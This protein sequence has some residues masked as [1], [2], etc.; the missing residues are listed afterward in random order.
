[1]LSKI[2]NKTDESQILKNRHSIVQKS[3]E[4]VNKLFWEHNFCPAMRHCTECMKSSS[5]PVIVSALMRIVA[6]GTLTAE[7]ASHRQ[8]TV[9]C[10]VVW[11][12]HPKKKK[13][14]NCNPPGNKSS[15]EYR[16]TIV[17]AASHGSCEKISTVNWGQID[18]Y[19]IT[20]LSLLSLSYAYRM[21]QND[22]IECAMHTQVCHPNSGIKRFYVVL[23]PTV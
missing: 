11:T 18:H 9:S 19:L 10:I 21:I 6:V 14:H 7:R 3:M 12:V 23:A 16:T 5:V 20:C 1:M 13:T 4:N 22:K 17:W 8:S 15:M 2:D